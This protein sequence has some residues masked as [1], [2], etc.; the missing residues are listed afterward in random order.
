M[1]PHE[2]ASL[3][4]KAQRSVA[5]AEGLLKT[6]DYDFAVSR[7]YY[8]MSYM[9]QALLLTRE[10]RRAKHSGVLA[11]FHEHFVR[12]GV[13]PDRFFH[14]LRTGFETRIEGDYGF[15]VSKEDAVARLDAAREFVHELKG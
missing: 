1:S 8:G 4:A 13:V 9:A 7:A 12:S 2:I 3:L 6:G 11:A 5:A 10:V 15:S 14:L